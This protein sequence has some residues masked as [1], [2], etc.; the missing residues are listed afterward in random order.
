M[1]LDWLKEG[2]TGGTIS[3]ITEKLNEYAQKRLEEVKEQFL[4][5]R[6]G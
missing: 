4:N 1:F 2:M 3:V 6:K 5:M